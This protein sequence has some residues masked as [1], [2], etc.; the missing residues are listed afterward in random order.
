MV[1]TRYKCFPIGKVFG[2]QAFYSNR[3]I[4]KHAMKIIN[5]I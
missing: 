1:N 3:V 4:S 2:S 5:N